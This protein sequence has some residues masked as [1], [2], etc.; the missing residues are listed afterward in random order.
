MWQ[1]SWQMSW[2]R[3]R[4]LWGIWR[5]LRK[6]LFQWMPTNDRWEWN[7]QTDLLQ[8]KLGSTHYLHEGGTWTSPQTGLHNFHIF[9]S[10]FQS[11]TILVPLRNRLMNMVHL[12]SQNS[13]KVEP[14]QLLFFKRCVVFNFFLVENGTSVQS[15]TKR[16]PKH[17][18]RGQSCG[19]FSFNLVRFDPL[20]LTLLS[21]FQEIACTG[22]TCCIQKV[23]ENFYI[24]RGW[25]TK[26]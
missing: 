18:K 14:N 26:N 9:A 2:R 8:L 20:T 13:S 4:N 15:G 16:V 25:V 12:R 24:C 11:G 1:M 23:K 17:A 3:C 21:L 7:A 10:D 22:P 19:L 5:L 6:R